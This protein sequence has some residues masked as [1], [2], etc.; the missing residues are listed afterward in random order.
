ME[1]AP[2][3]TPCANAPRGYMRCAHGRCPSCSRSRSDSDLHGHQPKVKTRVEHFTAIRKDLLTQIN[4]QD[5]LL[6]KNS[7]FQN[8][9]CYFQMPFFQMLT[10][11]GPAH[12]SLR[13]TCPCQDSLV[14]KAVHGH[15][16]P[17]GEE[18]RV[19]IPEDFSRI[20]SVFPSHLEQ[21]FRPHLV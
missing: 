21:V 3:R 10:G 2:L 12:F 18:E 4:L 13:P 9:M 1:G 5:T 11:N 15:R 7:K 19:G 20:C 6:T 14:G 17:S 8:E 16:G